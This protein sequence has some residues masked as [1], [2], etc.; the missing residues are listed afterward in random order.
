ML[1][2][3]LAASV[4][5]VLDSA[6]PYCA[7][8]WRPNLI[9][10]VSNQQRIAKM[11]NNSLLFPPMTTSH[12]ASTHP[13][14]TVI[15]VRLATIDDVLWP[16]LSAILCA[17]EL[18]RAERFHFERHRRQFVAAH[19]LK[20]LM[21]WHIA[22]LPPRDW[23][24]E[25]APGGK[26]RVGSA[27]SPFFNLS[28]CDGLVACAVSRELDLGVDIEP[29][30]REAPLAIAER[31]FAPAEQAWLRD[32]PEAEQS[33]GFFALWTLKE[34]FIK[35]TG[36]GLQQD[37]RQIV[38]SLDPLRMQFLGQDRGQ[39]ET[40]YWWHFHQRPVDPDHI[41]ALAWNGPDAAVDCRTLSFEMLLDAG[42]NWSFDAT[43]ADG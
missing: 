39:G 28:H 18:E 38:F 19:A 40:G 1:R 41:L 43:R 6:M 36:Q 42:W 3:A 16:Q 33:A 26:P 15:C 21:L 17:A 14:I 9:N 20:R 12:A 2:Y 5:F 34:A 35:A 32:Q 37:L 27:A 23:V 10:D 30:S 24:F 4:E 7:E 13:Q 8:R 29:L 31:M 22:K 11:G 25:T